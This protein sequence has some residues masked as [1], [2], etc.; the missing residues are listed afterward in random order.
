MIRKTLSVGFEN[1]KHIHHFADIHIRNLK[2]HKEYRQVFQKVYSKL[3]ENRDNSIIVLAGDIVHA[4]LDMSPELI[5]LTS[6]FFTKLSNI[7]P[8][9]IIPGNHDCNLNNRYRMDALQPIVNALS[10][11]NIHYIKKSGEYI[12]A[13]TSLVL[14]SVFDE[15]SKYPKA[16]D[17]K[18]KTK[19]AMFH[20][21]VE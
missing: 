6:D 7:A 17:I 11:P 3:K 13:D 15:P 5:E 4:K 21:S 14:F 2:R 10:N 20:G 18:A 1:L 8:L 19:I 16:K 9:I 12:V